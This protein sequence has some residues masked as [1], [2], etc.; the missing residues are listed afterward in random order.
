V[1][2]YLKYFTWLNREKIQEL[3]RAV[4]E[5]PEKREAQRTLAGE[6]TNLVHGETELRRARQASRVM[7]GEAMDALSIADI[8]DVF[9][10]VPSSQLDRVLFEGDGIALF[11][12]LSE[13]GLT[14]SKG[15][16]RRLIRSGG[17]YVN[18]VRRS[19]ES[20]RVTLGELIDGKVLVLRKGQKNY[21]LVHV[22]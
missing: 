20:S 21:R 8:L 22:K 13:S 9:D 14:G 6:V 18:N 10:D 4:S 5:A 11:D 2:S 3:E 17:A 16:A 12:L 15:E 19:E 1:I 7:F